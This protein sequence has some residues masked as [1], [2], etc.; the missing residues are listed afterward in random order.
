MAYG[1]KYS[2]TFATRADKDVELKI[3]QEGYSGAI[4][5]L[6]GAGLNLEYIPNS[7]DP[8]EPI[9]AS[10]LGISID[11]TDELSDIINFTNI[12]DRYNYVE[13]YVNNVIEWVG[14]IINDNVQV[15]Y[16]TGRK[17]A[18]FNATDGLGMLKDIPFEPPAGNTGVNDINSLLTILRTCFNAIG[19]KN[20]RNTVTMCSY[21]ANGM[22]DRTAPNTWSDPFVQ[23]Y[24]AYRNFLKDEYTYTNC[25]EII[26]NIAK[27]FGCRVFQADG[28]WWI[29]SVNEFAETNAY[30]TEYN[31]SGTRV[32]NLDGNLINTSSIIQPYLT[33]TSGLYF[34]DNSQLKILNKGFYKI[35]AE[36]NVETAQNYIPNG[37]LQDND[38]TEATYWTRSSDGDGTCTLEQNT[39]LDYYYFELTAPS[40]GPAGTAAVTL[41]SSSNAYVTTGDSLQLNITIGAN[42]VATPIGFIDITINTGS[43]IYYLNNDRNWQTTSTS[44]TV[45]NPKTSG[46]A[47]D[48]VLDL[49]TAIFPG[50]GQLSFTYRISEGINFLTLTNFVLKIKSVV[51]DY[52]LTG[53]LVDTEQYTYSTSFP[54]GSS[55]SDSF[56]PSCKGALILSN[57]TVAAG[58]YRYGM[59][60]SGE[61]FTLSELLVQQY[62]NTYGQ[63]IINLDASL[64]SFYTENINYP[65]LNAAKLIF[66]TDTD[67][68]SI[69]VSSKSYMLGNA[70][71]DLPNDQTNVT[72]L[73]ISNTEI[74]CT[75]VNKYS[76][77][78]STF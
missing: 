17:I 46:D 10:Q 70:T 50:S 73:Q 76:P 62:I 74:A 64:S 36:G 69:N 16:S 20:N 24:M 34:I 57:N 15:S 35:I 12:D 29:V 61:F 40:G 60:P 68:A 59:D 78:T 45:Y 52:N 65:I 72:L 42:S 14:F 47:Q 67:P 13:M 71:I 77:Q 8:Y 53:T 56:Y 63:N 55:G 31:T 54:Y 11:F 9:F 49:K 22:I 39:I 37:N 3:W 44:Y 41:N 30:Y 5:D 51:S 23:T 43:T 48:F 75:R 25:L 6:Q 28:K 32:N 21:F 7:D 58:W 27:S 38:G 26:T 33:N 4:I 66:A 1:Q 19:F 2:V 18:T